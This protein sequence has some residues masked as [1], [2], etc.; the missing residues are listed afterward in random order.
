M[1]KNLRRR[2]KKKIDGR[3]RE[4]WKSLQFTAV[5]GPSRATS[6]LAGKEKFLEFP[7]RVGSSFQDTSE[8]KVKARCSSSKMT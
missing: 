8:I 5:D 2:W 1:V 4:P 6:K 3:Q 7:E